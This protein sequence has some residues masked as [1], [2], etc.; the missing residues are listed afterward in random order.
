MNA[1]ALA[2]LASLPRRRLISS[3]TPLTRAQELGEAIG[4]IELWLKR[5][6]LI[7]FGFGGNKMR[8][9]ELMIA[10][11]RQRG[12]DI[13]VTGAGA[14]SNHVRA[15][16]A[17][18]AHAKL[19][20]LAVYWGTEPA[21][22][23][24]NLFLTRLLG[25]TTVFTGDDDRSTLDA[26]I[27][28][29]A[30]RLRAGGRK[31]Y[32]IPRGGASPLGTLGHVAAI[33]ELVEQCAAGRIEPDV[34]VLAVGS[35]STLAGWLLGAALLGVGWQIEGVPV[36]RSAAETRGRVVELAR[37][38]AELIG[39]ASPVTEEQVVLHDG[40][41]GGGYG[42]PTPE[43]NATIELAARRQGVF[44][45]PTYTAKAFAALSSRVPRQLKPGARVVF[46]HTGGEPRLFDENR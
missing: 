4:G 43:G 12:A 16:A 17:A 15:T 18:A 7:E 20:A 45:D 26:H 37:A 23:T 33:A 8:G 6:D 27:R 13:V 19:D 41:I 11:A 10:D 24:A 38:G 21:R 22:P 1:A 14:Y 25:A 29:H 30:D 31:P 5:E 40:F 2:R 34:V 3:P 35:G 9:L 39:A 46:V 42:V 44:F 32:V 36:S 28:D